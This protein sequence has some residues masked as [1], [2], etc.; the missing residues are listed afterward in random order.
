[1]LQHAR[2]SNS[3]NS[4][5]F[6]EAHPGHQTASEKFVRNDAHAM[7]E[8]GLRVAAEVFGGAQPAIAV[9]ENTP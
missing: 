6:S 7:C 8:S 1:V 9:E 2:F 5:V 3:L 4:N